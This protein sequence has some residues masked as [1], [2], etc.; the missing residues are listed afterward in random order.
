MTGDVQAL[1][2]GDEVERNKLNSACKARQ[3]SMNI[4]FSFPIIV[5]LSDWK[6]FLYFVRKFLSIFVGYLYFYDSIL[7]LKGRV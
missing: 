3:T 5:E 1:I 6:I 4:F 7:K 2:R